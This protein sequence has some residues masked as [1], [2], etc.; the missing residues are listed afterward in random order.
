MRRTKRASAKSS[1]SCASATALRCPS[2]LK[3][4]GAAVPVIAARVQA[5]ATIY[6]DEASHWDVLHSRYLTKR[7]NH[8]EAY[9]DGEA[10]TNMARVILLAP[11]PR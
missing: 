9:S 7:I 11:A 4:E 2:L 8:S 5:G 3:S 6:A 1:S 10:C